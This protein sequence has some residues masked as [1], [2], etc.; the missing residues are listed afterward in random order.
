MHWR[1]VNP[2]RYSKIVGMDPRADWL[3]GPGRPEFLP[4]ARR[5]IPFIMR[6]EDQDALDFINRLLLAPPET[7]RGPP[8]FVPSLHREPGIGVKPGRYITVLARLG[9]FRALAARDE[10]RVLREARKR[11]HLGLPMA[12]PCGPDWEPGRPLPVPAV[13]PVGPPDGGWPPG[14]VVIGVIDDGIAFAH[15]RFRTRDNGTRVQCFWHQDGRPDPGARTVDYGREV[16][17]RDF[18]PAAPGI[19]TLLRECGRAGSV[20]EEEVYRRAGSVDF[21]EPDHKAVAWR[22]AHGTHVLDL[23]AGED[24]ARDRRDRPIVCVQLPVAATADTS[25]AGLES[26]V[27]DGVKYILRRAADLAGDGP[28][29][30]VVINFSYGTNAGPHDGTFPLET[31]MDEVVA[32]RKAPVRFV[33]P[34]GNSHLSRGHAEVAFPRHPEPEAGEPDAPV[35]LRWRVQPDDMTRSI[36]ELWLPHAGA[37]APATSRVGLTIVPPWGE[38]SLSL[39]EGEASALQAVQNDQVICEARY[40]FVP[41]PTERGVFHVVLQPTARLLPTSPAHLADRVSMP[42]VW[43]VRL[44]NVSLG[45]DEKVQAWIER[46]DTAYGYAVRGRQSYFDQPCYAR[47]DEQG[48]EVEDDA[49]Q[50][51]CRVSRAGMI[52]S[53]ATGRHTIVA[54]G[55]LGRELRPASYSAGGPITPTPTRGVEAE[56]EGRK[57]DVL[58]VSDVSKVHGGVLAAGARSGS[59]VAMRGTSVAAPQMTRLIADELGAVIADH[60]AAGLPERA[61]D[62]AAARELAR[63]SEARLPASAPALPAHRGGWGR[64]EGTRSGIDRRVSRGVSGDD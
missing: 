40:Q 59:V 44:H 14:T 52:N 8:F 10:Y 54:G 34:A 48:R 13:A 55:F 57:P 4:D 46:D 27:Q 26:Y 33:L 21:A 28:A 58:L 38:G 15:E 42:G 19:D 50:E 7:G 60:P 63:R 29:L 56:A 30:P 5:L 24:P 47:F 39:G 18:S 41:A 23:A 3:L 49:D 51:P 2:G 9:F 62:R 32:G 64:V 16:W 31:F 17:K 35:V 61:G 53:I 22:A 12:R 36:L 45:P 20:D 1:K 43:E 6:V 37:T 25:G 11:I